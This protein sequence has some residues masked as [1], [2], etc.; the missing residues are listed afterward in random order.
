VI[1]PGAQR[2]WSYM[3]PVQRTGG[4]MPKWRALLVVVGLVVLTANLPGAPAVQADAFAGNGVSCTTSR[5]VLTSF[6]IQGHNYAAVSFHLSIPE[7]GTVYGRWEGSSGVIGTSRFWSAGT[8]GDLEWWVQSV[9]QTFGTGS[10]GVATY[11]LYKV[12]GYGGCY[13]VD[14]ASVITVPVPANGPGGG[15]I[16]P[17]PSQ[18]A[19]DPEATAAPSQPPGY[20]CNGSTNID[21]CDAPPS[22]WCWVQTGAMYGSVGY[23]LQECEDEGDDPASGTG[24]EAGATSSCTVTAYV[25]SSCLVTGPTVA[26]G[27]TLVA[28][29]AI[30]SSGLRN[31]ANNGT[32]VFSWAGSVEHVTPGHTDWEAIPGTQLSTSNGPS[33]GGLTPTSTEQTTEGRL[34]VS[35]SLGGNNWDAN[36]GSNAVLTVYWEVDGDPWGDS[37]GDG[38]TDDEEAACGSDPED[39]TDGCAAA[40][41]GFPDAS[42]LPEAPPVGGGPV[43]QCEGPDD[44]ALPMCG[45]FDFPTF[46]PFPSFTLCPS[47]APAIAACAPIGAERSPDVLAPDPSAAVAGFEGMLAN[48]GQKVPFGYGAQAIDALAEAG[49]NASGAG[50]AECVDFG[51]WHPGGTSDAELCIPWDEVATWAG[52]I[53]SVLL[54]VLLIGV[55]MAFV[56]LVRQTAADAN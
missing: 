16:T 34:S 37:D 27:Q 15:L 50:I 21:G 41:S 11:A 42:G 7:G 47:P 19:E 2:D 1:G 48:L 36:P 5:H 28:T 49:A 52:P 55:A 40:P 23:V 45:G 13:S 43:D 4:G 30:D 9:G 17:N 26:V 53:R 32:G 35:F 44:A 39:D 51:L 25:N 12:Q 3:A 18:F 31:R 46:P 24:G 29:I 33:S 6:S 56:V 38:W 14:D 10:T 20:D 8:D 22:G 54:A